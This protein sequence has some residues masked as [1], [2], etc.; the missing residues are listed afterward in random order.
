[1]DPAAREHKRAERGGRCST[2]RRSPFRTGQTPCGSLQ[3]YDKPLPRPTVAVRRCARAFVQ[4]PGGCARGDRRRRAERGGRKRRPIGI[5]SRASSRIRRSRSGCVRKWTPLEI[6]YAYSAFAKPRRGKREPISILAV[7]TRDGKLLESREVKMR[8]RRAGGASAYVDERHPE[9]TSSNYG[10]APAEKARAGLGVSSGSS[11]ARTGTTSNY[12]DAWFI[13]YS[14]RHP[15]RSC[16]SASTTAT[17]VRA[18]PG[19]DALRADLDRAHESDRRHGAR[20]STGSGRT[21]SVDRQGRSGVGDGWPPAVLSDDR[22]ARS[23]SPAPSRCRFCPLH[24][25]SG[26]TSPLLPRET[27]PQTFSLAA[28]AAPPPEG[29]P[30]QQVTPS[31]CRS[32]AKRETAVA[33]PPAADFW[34]LKTFAI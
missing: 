16:G 19:G 30:P 13:G 8:R 6:A 27:S 4:H 28:E 20:P 15:G 24:A 1:M 10:S 32:A 12:R 25:G 21:T 22:A 18:C 23:S 2:I 34:R 29:M 31:D 17:G 5:R 3:N 14:P 33:P 7:A 9:R 11:P 26:E